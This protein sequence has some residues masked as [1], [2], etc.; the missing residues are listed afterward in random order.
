MATKK[1]EDPL[2]AAYRRTSLVE[3]I[4]FWLR[5]VGDKMSAGL[6][7]EFEALLV[8][9][10][11]DLAKGR[12]PTASNRQAYRLLTDR[13]WM[14]HPSVAWYSPYES[15]LAPASSQSTPTVQKRTSGVVLKFRYTW[16]KPEPIEGEVEAPNE[17]TAR[18]LIREKHGLKWVPNNATVERIAS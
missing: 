2:F 4:K 17:R 8:K 18:A 9:G 5:N 1:T 11:S 12:M 15:P 14:E 6:R 10:E 7:A 16:T 3:D 13:Y